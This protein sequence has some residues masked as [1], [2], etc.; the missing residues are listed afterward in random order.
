MKTKTTKILLA[1]VVAA[2]LLTTSCKKDYTCKC[3]KT[4]TSGSGSST[5][6]YS[7]YTYK[8]TKTTAESR[9]NANETTSSDLGGNYSINCEIT[10]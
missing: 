2:T 8:D 6:N 3:S 10:D 7:T 5:Q 9:C 1:G 4:Y